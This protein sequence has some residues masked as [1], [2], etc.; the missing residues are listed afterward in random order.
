MPILFLILTLS[1]MAHAGSEFNAEF[2]SVKNT[3][4]KVRISGEEGT[5]FNLANSLAQE[6]FYHRISFSHKFKNKHGLRL[7]YAPLRLTGDD[8]Y[9]QNINFQGVQFNANQKVETE[10]QFN[11]YRATYF[12]QIID[13]AAWTAR[14]GLSAKVREAKVKL[15]QNNVSKFKKNSGVVPLL[16][17]YSE[18]KFS[19]GF[20]AALDFDG[21]AAPQ[22]R[23]F[24]VAIM[25]GYYFSPQFHAN[26]GFRML[27]GGVDNDT[28]YNFSQLNYLFTSL[29]INF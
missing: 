26:L 11:S 18:Y 25:G 16:Y 1:L 14:V 29:Q 28:V 7:L 23:A 10:Y 15:T 8:V 6:N 27:E 19:T 5:L 4:N 3:Y 9:S 24:D 13:E 17:F 12:Y 2:G 22:G 21:L 20:R